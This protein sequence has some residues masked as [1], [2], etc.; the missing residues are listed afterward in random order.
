MRPGRAM[1][2]ALRDLYDNSWRLVPVN[3]AIGVVLVLVGVAAVVVHGA[4]VLV[5]LAGPALAALVHASVTVV[6]TGNLELADAIE[7]LR[8]HWRRGLLLGAVG[9]AL[10]LLGVT[11]VRVYGGMRFGWPLVFL[12]V[13]LLA[14]LGVYQIV[15]WTL[16][17]AEPGRPLRDA[18]RSAGELF[19]ARPGA[20][21]VLGLA[22]FLVNLAGLAAAA[23]PFL[24]L[25][26]AYSFLA[27]AHYALPRPLTEVSA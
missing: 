15:L 3:A 22:L 13:Y 16:A 12:T 1:R 23:M 9:A 26:I 10:V 17:I 5:V 14:L 2:L 19:A 4:I 24:T 25:T 11:A 8:L 20:T 7:G 27:A 6:R 21:L 18:A